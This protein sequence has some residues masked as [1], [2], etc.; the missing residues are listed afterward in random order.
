[1][2]S[3]DE[4]MAASGKRYKRP[5]VIIQQYE[6]GDKEKGLNGPGS[7]KK[8]K[9]SDGLMILKKD[10]KKKMSTSS[11]LIPN[12]GTQ[13]NNREVIKKKKTMDPTE[14]SR[15][16]HY[17]GIIQHFLKQSGIHQPLPLQR[18]VWPKALEG[19]NL[20]IVAKPG[21]GK[22]LA[23]LLPIACRLSSLGHSMDSRPE[24]PLALVLL[25]TRELAQQVASVCR[26]IK[27]S[28]G[29]LRASCLT[30][31]SDKGK[32]IDSLRRGPHIVIATP[33]RLVDLLEEGNVNL[34][35]W[36]LRW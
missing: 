35:A 15:M 31:G 24:G 30:G 6:K 14:A 29:I 22:T 17:P 16:S 3:S 27:K 2:D 9:G 12:S 1:M 5:D 18:L 34:G 23:Y 36:C 28:C 4:D 20:H 19:E 32:Q 7:E 25:P 8:N 11:Q 33:G 13:L 26:H 10:G 21:S